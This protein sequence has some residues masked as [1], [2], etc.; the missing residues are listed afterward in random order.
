LL[1]S[2]DNPEAD[3]WGLSVQ[4]G[5]VV[6]FTREVL[7]GL[8]LARVNPLEHVQKLAKAATRG[9][10][11]FISRPSR[12]EAEAY[13]SFEHCYDETHE[14]AEPIAGKID[15]Y[16]L[17]LLRRLGPA[18]RGRRISHWPEGSLS[19]SLPSGLRNPA[20][21]ALHFLAACKG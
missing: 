7:H 17:A 19:R 3:A 4:Q 21:F 11:M 20:L 18:Y 8:A 14:A 9:V 12:A 16:P 10:R 5:A 6:T 13:G 2:P 15:F 1:A